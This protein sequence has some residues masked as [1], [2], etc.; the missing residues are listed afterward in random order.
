MLQEEENSSLIRRFAVTIREVSDLAKTHIVSFLILII[1]VSSSGQIPEIVDGWPYYTQT[2]NKPIYSVPVFS[3][4]SNHQNSSIFFNNAT[5]D[6]DKFGFDSR[7]FPGWPVIT[8]PVF[9]VHPPIVVDID[10]DGEDEVISLGYRIDGHNDIPRNYIYV[11][12]DDGSIMP[13]FPIIITDASS[14]NVADLDG[15]G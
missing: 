13:G 4:K 12:D 1:S 5:F 6:I 7:Q 9:Y 10:H 11:I 3:L 14:L 15:D 8:D 2:L